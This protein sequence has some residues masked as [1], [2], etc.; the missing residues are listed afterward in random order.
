MINDEE[1]EKK[2][3]RSDYTYNL[4]KTRTKGSMAQTDIDE[5]EITNNSTGDKFTATRTDHTDLRTFK[6]TK[7]WEL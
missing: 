3:P 4:V 6:V 2:Y 7:Y 5:Y 1:F